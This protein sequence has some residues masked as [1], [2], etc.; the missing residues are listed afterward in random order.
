MATVRSRPDAPLVTLTA[1]GLLAIS[2]FLQHAFATRQALLFL[3]GTGLGITLFHASFGFTGGW[4]RFVRK[5]RGASVRA[6]LM[7]LAL[8]SLLFFPILG[9]LFP[10]I[11]VS[12]ALGPVSLSVLVGAFLFGAGMQ[13][14]GGCGS[15]TLFTVGGGQ[16]RM[17]ITLSFFIAGTLLGTAHLPWW[18]ALPNLGKLSVIDALGWMPALL[19]QVL[20]LGALY[21]LVAALERRR[22]GTTES[23][24]VTGQHLPF[25]ERLLFGPWTLWWGVAGLAVL[26]LLTLLVAGHPWSITF[27]FGL[28]GA[29]IWMA[30]G[31]DVSTWPYWSSGYPA[32]ALNRSVL[33]DTTSLMDFGI[34]L[35]AVLAAGLAGRFAPPGRLKRNAVLTAVLGGLLLGYGARLA[36]GCNIGGMLAGIVSGSIHGWLWLVAGFLGSMLGVRLRAL[37]GLDPPRGT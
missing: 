28:W 37:F 36:F 17:L 25:S 18:L 2:L 21:L 9:N 10:Q 7:L 8:T 26:S 6:Q 30:L 31:G 33:A 23:L 14:G 27:A 24:G 19:I 3:I 34:I 22:H 32:V 35:G 16:V 15:G 29:K 13:L 20:V 11:N 5:R 4:R 12:A 1:L